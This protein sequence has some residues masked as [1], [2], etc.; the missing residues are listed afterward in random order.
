MKMKLKAWVLSMLSIL[1]F[2]LPTT[3]YACAPITEWRNDDADG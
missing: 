3:V 1:I 2:C